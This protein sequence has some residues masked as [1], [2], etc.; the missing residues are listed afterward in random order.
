MEGFTIPEQ[1]GKYK[2]VQILGRGSFAVIA[3]GVDEKTDQNVAI[4][5]FD[6]KSFKEKGFMKYL[7]MELRLS[8][9]LNH[10]CLPKFYGTLYEKDFICLLME[11]LPNGNLID[12][13][14]SGKH[15]PFSERID[16]CFKILEGL[17]YLHERGIS[18]RDLKPENIAFDD[19]FNPKIIDLGLAA[20]YSDYLL[21]YCGTPTCMA[22]EI[23]C[24][25]CYDGMKADI[26]SFGVTAHILMTQNF[27]FDLVSIAKYIKQVKSGTLEIKNTCFGILGKIIEKCL[28]MDP[29]K[30]PSA[31]DLIDHLKDFISRMQPSKPQSC[32]ICTS[33]IHYNDENP[34]SARRQ[35][36]QSNHSLV[37]SELLQF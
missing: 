32:M 29:S 22:P 10:P 13:L 8:E 18:H 7:D 26:W 5:I 6:R 31:K 19:K 23:L 15:L 3:L 27:P 9:R 25:K 36:F 2:I 16:I 30:R 33:K 14:N 12:L 28:V 21:T 24:H 17:N 4:K 1:I 35:A 37:L 34:Y 20:E 11:Y